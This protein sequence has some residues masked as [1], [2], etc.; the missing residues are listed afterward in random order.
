MIEIGKNIAAYRAE[1][2]ETQADLGTFLGVSDKTISKWESG[3]TEPNL[4]TV[5]RIAEHY[6]V[7][8]DVLLGK[9]YEDV[10]TVLRN[11]FSK[12]KNQNDLFARL[13][14]EMLRLL[15]AALDSYNDERWEDAGPVIIPNSPG[16]GRM[17][18][19]LTT[20]V[21]QM[22]MVSAPD[23][24]IGV[25]QFQNESNFRWMM[26][27]PE[28]LANLFA[29]FADP[30]AVKLMYTL[31]RAD[32]PDTF[33]A[34]Y[35]AEKA[36]IPCEKATEILEKLSV[37]QNDGVYRISAMTADMT[38]GTVK[39]YEFIGNGAYLAMMSMA[40]LIVYGIDRNWY[41]HHGSCKLI[42]EEE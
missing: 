9:P 8:V 34:G 23:M 38:D 32:F 14:Q 35:A 24:N 21:G 28:D 33:T 16:E 3:D 42:R 13:Y 11:E 19:V 27:T 15:H 22:C 7:T 4:D 5:C 40:N 12:A 41:A 37:Y 25:A 26:D 6:G 18:S 30:C 17:R 10:Q 1:A 31:C 2:K 39:L 29:V 36:G 20:D